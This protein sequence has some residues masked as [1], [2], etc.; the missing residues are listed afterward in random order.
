MRS[1]HA[2][3]STA[4]AD[5][6]PPPTPPARPSR[7]SRARARRGERRERQHPP[8][9]TKEEQEKRETRKKETKR[10][11]RFGRGSPVPSRLSVEGRVERAQLNERARARGAPRG[12]RGA[13]WREVCVCVC[14]LCPGGGELKNPS[15][16]RECEPPQHT[17]HC[18]RSGLA[19]GDATSAPRLTTR[20]RVVVRRRSP[21]HDDG[22]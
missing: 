20:H 10:P 9:K 1:S 8:N 17:P 4:Q 13:S 18:A 11:A 21:L 16:S 12:S 2:Q 6:D 5:R 19:R 7:A 3:H 15:S 22:E 14:V